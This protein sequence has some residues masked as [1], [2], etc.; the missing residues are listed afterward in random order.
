MFRVCLF[1]HGHM[2]TTLLKNLIKYDCEFQICWSCALDS[3]KKGTLCTEIIIK[4]A[5]IIFEKAF[6]WDVEF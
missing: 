3:R 2:K 5:I 6:R 1:F 4:I